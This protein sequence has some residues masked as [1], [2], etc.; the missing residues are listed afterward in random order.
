MKVLRI[1]AFSKDGAGG[2]PAGVVLQDHMPDAANMQRVAAEVG[3]SETVFAAPDGDGFRVRYF[4]PRA[5]VAFCGHATIA[6]GAAL[7][8]AHGHGK[9]P[10]ILNAAKISVEAIKTDDGWSAQ[11]QSPNTSFDAPVADLRQDLLDLF[12]WQTQDLATGFDL[13]QA[14]GGAEHVLVP[15]GSRELLRDMSYDF[16]A[17]AALM[18]K[19]N[20]VTINLFVR[21][22]VDIIYSRNPFA[23]HGVY[24]DPATGAAAAALGGYLRDGRGDT[25]AFTV[26]QGEDMGVPS[27]LL[28]KPLPGAGEPVLIAGDTRTIMP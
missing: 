19:H 17:G 9:Y 8:A 2:N 13:I 25:G 14:N 11:L 3:Y 15:L 21:Q 10:I 7:G 4:A 26:F 24:E 22:G 6:L 16:D 18:Q 27:R 1:A 5:E 12:G 23:G 28:V 20:L